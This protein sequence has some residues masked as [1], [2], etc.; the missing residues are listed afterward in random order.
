MKRRSRII[1]ALDVETEE[2]ALE[3]CER[4]KESVDA[5]KVGHCL[6]MRTGIGVLSKL[7]RFGKPII[8]DLKVAD[9]PEVSRRMCR[10]AVENGADYVIVHGI[11]GE[12]V[13]RACAEAADIFVVSEMSHGGAEEFMAG[14]AGEVAE[15]AKRHAVGIVAPATRPERIK[16]MRRIVGDLIIISPGVKAQGAEAGSAVKAGADFEI[17]GRGIYEAEDPGEAARELARAISG[18]L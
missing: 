15:M 4:T 10:A 14:H 1:L 6:L 11:F 8:A 18:A 5:Y 12:D 16:K 17:I 7:R 9:I 3:L 2:D 13:V